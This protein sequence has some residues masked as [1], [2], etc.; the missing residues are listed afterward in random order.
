MKIADKIGAGKVV[1]L[2]DEEMQRQEVTVRDMQTKKQVSVK[3]DRLV[4]YL[5]GGQP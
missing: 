3:I 5:Q 2:G 4:E 1:M